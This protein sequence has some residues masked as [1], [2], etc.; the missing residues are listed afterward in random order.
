MLSNLRLFIFEGCCRRRFGRDKRGIGNWVLMLP[1]NNNQCITWHRKY[2]QSR[3]LYSFQTNRKQQDSENGHLS[4]NALHVQG[5]D[6]ETLTGDEKLIAFD[7]TDRGL[8]WLNSDHMPL[9]TPEPNEFVI[10]VILC[11]WC[12]AQEIVHYEV[13]ESGDTVIRNLYC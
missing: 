7:N 11:I 5:N 8:Q 9:K 12:N 3:E 2:V 10:K 13:L 4:V 6:L 1:A